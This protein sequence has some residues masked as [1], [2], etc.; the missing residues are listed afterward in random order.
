MVWAMTEGRER[1]YCKAG[2][3]CGR[4][5]GCLPAQP[6]PCTISSKMK[7][8][9]LSSSNWV[10]ELHLEWG[11]DGYVQESLKVSGGRRGGTGQACKIHTGSIE[12]GCCMPGQHRDRGCVSFYFLVPDT[13]FLT[14]TRGSNISYCCC[15]LQSK[16]TSLG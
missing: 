15:M 9:Y 4:P 10:E 13:S 5:Q 12:G 1:S 16:S 11:E 14:K 2:Y 8:A 6:L 7:G 3:A